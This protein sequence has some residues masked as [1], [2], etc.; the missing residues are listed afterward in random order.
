MATSG[1]SGGR[2]GTSGSGWTRPRILA[3]MIAGFV[4]IL[5]IVGVANVASMTA[6]LELA[7]VPV[8]HWHVWV[9]EGSSIVL[10]LL[11][12]PLIWIMVAWAR[13]PQMAWMW[14]VPLHLLAT[15]PISLLHV[16]GSVLLRDLAYALAGD[17]YDFGAWWPRWFYEYRKDVA[18]YAQMAALAA[19]AQ[20]ALA[21]VGPAPVVEARSA[22]TLEVQEGAVTHRVP[23]DEIDLVTAAGNYVELAWRGRTLL[24]RATLAAVEAELGDAFVRIHRSR[25]V[26]RAA[27]RSVETN[28][29]GDFEVTLASGEKA[30][31]SRRYRAGLE[32]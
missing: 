28:Q 22:P 5:L 25:I 16:G 17:H 8:T 29:A 19:L 7:H 6:D 18:T 20:W 9:W 30:K 11:L 21:R 4:A 32:G 31:G 24:H 27:I 3:V 15:L 14:A 10:W 2:G 12:A 23:I 1:T 26:R 13:P